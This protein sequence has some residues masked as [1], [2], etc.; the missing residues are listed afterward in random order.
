VAYGCGC[1]SPASDPEDID[2][3]AIKTDFEFLL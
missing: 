3:G 1:T 2:L